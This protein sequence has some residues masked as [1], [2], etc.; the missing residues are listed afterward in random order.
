M[1]I[2]VDQTRAAP[3]LVTSSR[4]MAMLRFV[5]SCGG[6]PEEALGL[7]FRKSR[8]LLSKLRGAG[9]IYRVTAEGKV[10]WLPAGVPPPGDRNDFERRFAVGWLAARLFES[11]GCYEEDTAVFPN[12]A[13]FRVAVAP[14]APA[15]TCLVVFLAGATRLVQGSVWVLLNEIQRKSLKECL[16]S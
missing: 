9:V 14:P 15:D 12:G 7:V 5:E 16:K 2:I 1:R 3:G 10:L 4:A 13:V 8:L 11:G 6:A